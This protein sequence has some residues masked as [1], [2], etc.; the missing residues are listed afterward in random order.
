M[1]QTRMC[2][3]L[4]LGNTPQA[5]QGLGDQICRAAGLGI[6]VHLR[7]RRRDPLVADLHSDM[8]SRFV[9]AAR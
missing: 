5:V 6:G 1:I 3:T 2:E 9:C 4:N 7:P 8:R